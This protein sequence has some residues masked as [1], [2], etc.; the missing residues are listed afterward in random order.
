MGNF[1]QTLELSHALK[2]V[3][4]HQDWD[5]HLPTLLFAYWTVVHN[6]TMFTP[7]S[8]MFGRSPTC[9]LPVDVMLGR[10]RAQS[11]LVQLYNY[12]TSPTFIPPLTPGGP[13]TVI[14]EIKYR[15]LQGDWLEAQNAWL[16]MEIA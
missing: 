10:T 14:D 15:K 8:V 5:K 7:L 16:S 4:D 12:T 1:N 9:T 11:S 3:A 13:Y 6:S 2:V